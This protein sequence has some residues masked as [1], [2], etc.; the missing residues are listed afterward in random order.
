MKVYDDRMQIEISDGQG[1]AFLCP[2]VEFI[3]YEP[4]Y[5]PLQLP[6]ILRY[7]DPIYQ[8]CSTSTEQVPDDHY[9]WERFKQYCGKIEQYQAAYDLAHPVQP[10][11]RPEFPQVYVRLEVSGGDGHTIPAVSPDDPDSPPPDAQGL[12]RSVCRPKRCAA[13]SDVWHLALSGDASYS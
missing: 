12:W 6:H 1:H 3:N 2:S 8:Y 13:D 4:G 5:E 11:E 7:W 10:S 9:T